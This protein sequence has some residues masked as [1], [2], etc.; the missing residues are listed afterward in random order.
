[1]CLWSTSLNLWS[2]LFYLTTN[3]NN[4]SLSF[5]QICLNP[6][7]SKVFA[8]RATWGVIYYMGCYLLHGT[9]IFP[10]YKVQKTGFFLRQWV[11][12]N[13]TFQ[14]NSLDVTSYQ[15]S[16]PFPHGRPWIWWILEI[17][18]FTQLPHLALTHFI[19]DI[20]YFYL[21]THTP[22]PFVSFVQKIYWLAI[23]YSPWA[24]SHGC[25]AKYFETVCFY[26]INIFP[27]YCS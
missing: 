25:Y 3:T 11:C 20:W 8:R 21:K 2:L 5:A 13:L 4:P 27:S 14:F 17:D 16:S 9:I 1:M 19:D 23:N 18:V 24:M 15:M 22:Y 7:V 6:G 10:S 12:S 26:E